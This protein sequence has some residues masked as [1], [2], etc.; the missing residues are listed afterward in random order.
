MEVKMFTGYNLK[1]DKMFFSDKP[2]S[3]GY[4]KDIGE[5]HLND[6]INEYK[7]NLN[8]YIRKGTINGS[9]LQNDIFPIIDADVFISHSHNDKD[10]A[11]ALAGWI[12][13]EFGL[14]VFIDS[15]VWGYSQELLEDINSKYSNKRKDT[16]SSFL[17]DHDACSYASQHVNIM[18]SVALHK[19]IDTVECVILLNTDNSITIFDDTNKKMN[20]TYSPWIY[21]EIVCTQIVRKKPLLYYREYNE[22]AHADESRQYIYAMSKLQI[23]YNVSL[24]HLTDLSKGDL[25]K[26]KEIH[27]KDSI[28]FNKYQ[29]YS[30]DALYSFKHPK[31]YEYAK[32]LSASLNKKH[33][34]KLR[35]FIDGNVASPDIIH[36]LVEMNLICER[37]GKKCSTCKGEYCEF[38][39]KR[40]DLYE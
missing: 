34:E 1:I 35:K 32:K 21:S 27:D 20:S 14:K 29:K 25:N 13:S 2:K 33:I 31:E 11:N 8:M 6:Q 24:Q 5:N 39:S 19:M 40:R 22:F 36:E 30:L 15:N 18:L 16:N 7:N 23:S 4:Y 28:T 17:Y 37:E 3:F 38:R 26:W 12:H 9:E 10:L